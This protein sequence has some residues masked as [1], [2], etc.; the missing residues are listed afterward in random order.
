MAMREHQ[1]EFAARGYFTVAVDS[2]Y[3]P[4]QSTVGLDC[5]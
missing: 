2:S 4:V 1:E 5:M 3:G